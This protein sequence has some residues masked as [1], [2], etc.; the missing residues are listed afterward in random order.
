VRRDEIETMQAL[1]YDIPVSPEEVDFQVEFLDEESEPEPGSKALL[2]ASD[3]MP[4][5]WRRMT[6]EEIEAE[7]Y[8]EPQR[9]YGVAVNVMTGEKRTLGIHSQFIGHP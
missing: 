3:G 5:G 4:S 6:P 7:R 1:G 9:L 8:G 2:P